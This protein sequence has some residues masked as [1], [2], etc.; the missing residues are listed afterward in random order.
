MLKMYLYSQFVSIALMGS[1]FSQS[2]PEQVFTQIYDKGIWGKDEQGKGTSGSGSTLESAM[3]YIVFLNKFIRTNN[4]KTIVDVGCGDWQIMSHVDLTGVDYLGIDV[5][6]SV[7]QNNTARY[8]SSHV[9]FAVADCINDA[10]PR[11]DLLLC[12]DVFNHL[13]NAAVFKVIHQFKN[14]DHVL[15]TSDVEAA[16]LT[17]SNRDIV[18]GDWRSIDL[19]AQPFCQVGKKILIYP[20]E[21]TYNHLKQVFYIKNVRVEESE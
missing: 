16:T 8:A 15:V 12:K 13:P 19:S 14:Y 17:C 3:E 5:V 2:T 6:Q 20:A 4:I 10:L 11:G 9:N 7:I 21:C 18:L 1:L